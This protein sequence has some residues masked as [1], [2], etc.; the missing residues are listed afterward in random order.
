MRQFLIT[1]LFALSSL[2]GTAQVLPGRGHI[3]LNKLEKNIDLN[4]DITQLSLAELRVLRNAFAARQGYPFMSSDLRGIFSGTSW[5]ND[6]MMERWEKV[7]TIPFDDSKD[8]GDWRQNYLISDNTIG[9]KYT[10]A[11]Q[12]FIQKIQARER[13]LLK[14]NF[15]DAEGL[16]PNPENIINP[17]QLEEMPTEIMKAF[18][19][20]GFAIVPDVQDQLFHIYEKNDYHDVP[21][22]VTTDLYLQ[23]F[24]LY[25]DCT[26]REAEQ[27]K[28]FSYMSTLCRG[29]YEEMTARIQN[30]KESKLRDA[31]EYC[32]AYYAVACA[33]MDKSPLPAVPARYQQ[34][35]QAEVNNV[36]EAQDRPSEFMGF[37]ERIYPY[38]LY[39]PR[40]HYTRTDSLSRYFRTMMWLQTVPMTSN[41]EASLLRA[42]IMAQAIGKSPRLLA[43]YK[44]LTEP[45]TYLM[46]SPDNITIMQVY[47]NML[48]L[49]MTSDKQ[50]VNKS[51]LSS[52]R[53]AV[54]ETAQQQTVIKPKDLPKEQQKSCTINLMPQRYQPDGEVMQE[55]VDYTNT[56]TLRKVPTGLDIVAAMGWQAAERI[57]I[58]ERQEN[59]HWDG[60]TT[61]LD[62][63]KR[64]MASIDWGQTVTNR[65]L[66]SLITL[67]KVTPQSPYFMKNAQWQKK[68]LNA[69]LASWAE[70]KHDAI[71]YAKQPMGA[72][73]G[74]GGPPE[75][76][77][78]GYVEPNIAFWQ[79]A[80]DLV[81]TTEKVFTRYQL[82]T[83]KTAEVTDRLRDMLQFMLK[84]SQKELEGK[85]ITNE[86][87]DQISIAGSN[88]E[89]L[90]LD[91]LRG[92]D[93]DVYS[94]TDVQGADKSI[95]VV[96]DVFTASSQNVPIPDKSILYEAVGPAYEIY[97][98]VP[99]DGYLYLMRGGVFSYRE[100]QRAM[101]E[102]R[103]TDE[104]WQETLKTKPRA[105][106]PDWMQ[107]IIVK[108]LKPVS[109]NET[110]FYSSGC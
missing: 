27:G 52:L 6:R 90:T 74:G 33:L 68:S 81:N 80:I 41:N 108:P 3:D 29:M 51:L 4:M 94:W 76:V 40:G 46:G 102:P 75:P 16:H 110:F 73:C 43:A 99:L 104:E 49:N 22:F 1:A 101:G 8:T 11:E 34:L 13:E 17:Y 107:E 37:K 93:Q 86:E 57:L 96:A 84:I 89:Y 42:M 10:P 28:L 20:Q 19:R 58:D 47:D 67:S 5:Y 78:K 12:A 26:L 31:A 61:M 66:S 62:S 24:H 65:W 44:Q 18:Q 23:L 14:Q 38:S 70:L 103:W 53:K 100:F 105:G 88:C 30:T 69:A 82:S 50:L 35:A 45:I 95:A 7:E 83:E 55:M 39:R 63:M 48:R 79:K 25:F 109:D 98:I 9:L 36:N 64:R 32:V 21:S 77:T 60:Y 71:L 97:V 54:E 85:S 15:T 56:P 72:E 106:E 87:Y 2:T 92:Q 59:K 91:L